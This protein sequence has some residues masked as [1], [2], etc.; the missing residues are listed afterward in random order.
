MLKPDDVP[1]KP[2][3]SVAVQVFVPLP[4]VTVSSN[5]I[6]PVNRNVPSVLSLIDAAPAVRLG[7]SPATPTEAVVVFS[8]KLEVAVPAETFEKPDPETVTA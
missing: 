1:T 8:V 5:G 3:E 2:L 4:V 6:V 7:A